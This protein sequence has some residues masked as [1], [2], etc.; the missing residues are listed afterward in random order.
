MRETKKTMLENEPNA[1]RPSSVRSDYVM[2]DNWK[3]ALR[4]DRNRQASIMNS[5]AEDITAGIYHKLLAFPWI[6]LSELS[7]YPGTS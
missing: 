3:R 7:I 2:T 6:M 1:Q 4:R 5:V